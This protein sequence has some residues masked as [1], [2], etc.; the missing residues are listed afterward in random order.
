M[1]SHG[2]IYWNELMTRD[3]EASK[4]FY[5]DALGWTYEPM[6]MPEATYWIAKMGAAPVAGIFP[7]TSP[8]FDP[9]PEAWF[10]YIAV[11]DADA[12]AKKI[13]A[14][15]GTIL[16]GP[17]DVPQVGRIVVVKDKAGVMFGLMRPLAEP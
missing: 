6:P 2:S 7:L 1:W 10:T 11:D 16:R 4:K 17:F 14:A 3:A 15:G 13:T 9:V 12:R 8:Q 5:G